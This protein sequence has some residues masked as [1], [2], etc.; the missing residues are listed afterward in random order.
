MV[1]E[2]SGQFYLQGWDVQ[3]R[4]PGGGDLG[5]ILDEPVGGYQISKVRVGICRQSSCREVG[6]AQQF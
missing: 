5:L 4:L 3:R 2:G 6:T 1:K